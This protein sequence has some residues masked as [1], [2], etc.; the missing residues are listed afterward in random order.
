MG[1]LFQPDKQKKV[2]RINYYDAGKKLTHDE[3]RKLVEWG[4][5]NGYANL[6]SMPGLQAVLKNA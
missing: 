3:T 4:L 1:L 6:R 2:R 5:K